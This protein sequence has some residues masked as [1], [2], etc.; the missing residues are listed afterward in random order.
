MV[1]A[2]TQRFKDSRVHRAVNR[3]RDQREFARWQR[4][5]RP[6]PTPQACKRV[7]IHDLSARLGAR[8]FIETGTNFGHTVASA[9]G[10]FDT[11]YSIELDANLWQSSAK[12]FS[13]HPQV[14]LRHG[15]SARE[16]EAV[17]AELSEPALFWLD[18]HY[19]GAGTAR[20]EEDSPILRELEAIARHRVR[21]HVLLIDDAR[22][23]DGTAGYPTLEA[24]RRRVARWWPDHD[25]DVRDD[26]ISIVPRRSPFERAH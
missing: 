20:G 7:L 6:Q 13:R 16:L 3:W 10:C 4:A 15:D 26:V 18:A 23:F 19:S 25:F 8:V 24:C 22:L 1:R 12:R 2:L 5:G 21:D 17:L 9:I 14:R 11:I